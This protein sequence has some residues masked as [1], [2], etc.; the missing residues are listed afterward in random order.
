MSTMINASSKVSLNF[1]LALETGDVI[2]STFDDAPA[3]F[4]MGDGSLLPGF[5]AVLLGLSAGDEQSFKIAP[6]DAFGQ[7][8]E[9]NFQAIPKSAFPEDEE[10]EIGLVMSFE[11]GPEGELPGVIHAFE[12][13]EVI[14]NFNHPLAG[15]TLGFRVAIIDVENA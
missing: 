7:S 3:T 1:E 9:S 2:D 12:G 5:E 4:T 10:L 8:N 14:V 13:D 6:E 11:N 15:Q